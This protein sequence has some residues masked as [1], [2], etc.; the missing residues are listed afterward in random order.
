MTKQALFVLLKK[1]RLLLDDDA[2][3]REEFIQ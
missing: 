2:G 1:E 3:I